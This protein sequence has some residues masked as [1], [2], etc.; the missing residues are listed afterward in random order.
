VAKR[1]RRGVVLTP[2]GLQKFQETRLK[3]EADNNDGERYTYEKL[4][5]ITYL[6]IHTIKRV[7]ECQERVDKRT[8]RRLFMSFEIELTESCYTKPNLNKRQDWAKAMWVD[9]CYSRIE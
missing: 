2:E 3:S 6:D 8:L 1:R 9:T 5:E 4:S 7:I